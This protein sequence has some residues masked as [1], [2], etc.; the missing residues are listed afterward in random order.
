[1]SFIAGFGIGFAFGGLVFA[2]AN[3]SNTKDF[4]GFMEEE[5]KE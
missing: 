5:D 4:D 3:C 2:I 1:M